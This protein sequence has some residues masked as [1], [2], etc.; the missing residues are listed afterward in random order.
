MLST[1]FFPLAI[2][3]LYLCSICLQVLWNKMWPFYT[4]LGK[5]AEFPED[6]SCYGNLQGE[7]AEGFSVLP[8]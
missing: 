4:E 3:S 2:T 7:M 5:L 1:E 6:K 8:A